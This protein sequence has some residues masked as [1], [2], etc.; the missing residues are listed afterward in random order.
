[1]IF[2][3]VKPTTKIYLQ[4]TLFGLVCTFLILA[5][6]Q[7]L[8]QKKSFNK[9]YAAKSTTRFEVLEK[10]Q[11]QEQPKA[12]TEPK[13]SSDLSPELDQVLEGFSF[14]LPS[15]ELDLSAGQA[16]LN[17]ANDGVMSA[18]AVDVLPK[19]LTQPELNYPASAAEKGIQGFVE[20]SL[21]VSELGQ[22]E[23]VNILKASPKG[24][25][26]AAAQ[27]SVSQWRFQPAEYKGKKVAVWLNQTINFALE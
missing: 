24:V 7:Y 23:K 19:S 17:G 11:A 21:L 27:A 2:N 6:L 8:N 1:M 16:L 12:S 13:K 25:F 5:L 18:Q 14:G 15:L 9:N 4:A 26:E 3:H 10:K 22:V 20:V